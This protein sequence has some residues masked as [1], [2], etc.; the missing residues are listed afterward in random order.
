MRLLVGCSFALVGSF[1]SAPSGLLCDFHAS[2]ALG[3]RAAPRFTWIVPPC[4]AGADHVQA[5]Y[6]LTVRDIGEQVIWDSKQVTSNDSTYVE[7]AGPALAGGTP[8]HWTVTTWTT[9]QGGGSPCKSDP[10]TPAEFVTSLDT[11]GWANATKFITLKDGSKST[12]GYFRSEIDV[13]AGVMSASAFLTGV[14]AD[15]LEAGYKFYINGDLIDIGPG[16]G[17][18][19][20]WEGDG[21]FRSL[22]YMTLDVSEQL[23][24]PT[25]SP[26]KAALAFEGMH[27]SNP[28]VVLQLQLWMRDG[29][30][31]TTGTDGTWLGFNGD[32]HRK[33]GPARHGHRSVG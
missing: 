11:V 5:S 2:P 6:Q 3:V 7:Y 22:P 31:V 8:Y 32:L 21:T 10:S 9:P 4:S 15:P 17:E 28:T 16:R 30:V 1:A 27:A 23:T 14:N 19:P 33:P 18:A 24:S 29:S 20:V 26:F 13:P 25:S 12:F